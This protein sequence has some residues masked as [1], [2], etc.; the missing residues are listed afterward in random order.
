MA[1]PYRLGSARPGWRGAGGSGS[2]AR[3]LVPNHAPW[4][5]RHPGCTFT[6]VAGVISGIRSTTFCIGAHRGTQGPLRA[7][8]TM[9]GP[10]AGRDGAAGARATGGGRSGEQSIPE[11]GWPRS[12]I[13]MFFSDTRLDFSGESRSF[14]RKIEI[15]Y[16][17][18]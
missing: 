5:S 18:Q 8:A 14:S 13:A 11:Y 15:V 9:R 10:I 7:F 3:V 1:G 4:R 12:G 16:P 17:K 2:V 6:M